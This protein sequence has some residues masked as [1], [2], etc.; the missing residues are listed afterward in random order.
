[1][2]PPLALLLLFLFGDATAAA[3][4]SLGLRQRLLHRLELPVDI[5]LRVSFWG[6]WIPALFSSSRA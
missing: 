2:A 1:M 4:A 6:K 5:G 3:L